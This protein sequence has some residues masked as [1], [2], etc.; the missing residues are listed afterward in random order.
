MLAGRDPGP[1]TFDINSCRKDLRMMLAE[2]RDRGLALPVVEQTLAC[3][4]QASRDGFGAHDA[5]R[6][7]VYWATRSPP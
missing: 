4:D 2:G 7:S 1:A 6:Q 5:M 3:F